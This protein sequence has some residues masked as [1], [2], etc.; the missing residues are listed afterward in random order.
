VTP[1]TADDDLPLSFCDQCGWLQPGPAAA[2]ARCGV[3]LDRC[4][5]D[6]F[7]AISQNAAIVRQAIHGRAKPSAFGRFA[8]VFLGLLYLLYSGLFLHS[9]VSRPFS[10][11]ALVFVLLDLVIGLLILSA[12]HRMRCRD[13]W[14]EYRRWS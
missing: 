7:V 9:L 4:V 13:T 10:A 6:P 3:P 14:D 12:F 11:V 2:C 1:W 8:L 5:Y